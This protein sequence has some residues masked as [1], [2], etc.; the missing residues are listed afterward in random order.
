MRSNTIFME[1]DN[2]IFTSYLIIG[3]YNN[4]NNNSEK[5]RCCDFDRTAFCDG[6]FTSF[7][8]LL[9]DLVFLEKVIVVELQFN[10]KR[11]KD[12]SKMIF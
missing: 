2:R 1:N 8:I 9:V 11:K 5:S 7:L 3:S 6:R 10:K 4:H 12:I